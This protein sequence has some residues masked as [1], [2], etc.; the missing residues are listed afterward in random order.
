MMLVLT[1]IE[2]NLLTW[3]FSYIHNLLVSISKLCQPAH[4][5]SYGSHCLTFKSINII[6]WRL[7]IWPA[8]WSSP[9]ATIPTAAA[10]TGEIILTRAGDD[11]GAHNGGFIL[12]Q[13]HTLVHELV[14][15]CLRCFGLTILAAGEFVLTQATRAGEG[16]GDQMLQ[17]F[18]TDFMFLGWSRVFVLISCYGLIY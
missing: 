15:K 5:S 11:L 2:N 17:M 9:T 7:F 13:T 12:T 18:W 4:I 6:N 1:P 16:A 8:V 3:W 10:H 14:I